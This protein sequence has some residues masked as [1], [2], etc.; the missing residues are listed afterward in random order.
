MLA[1][2]RAA[3]V[4]RKRTPEPWRERPLN[5]ARGRSQRATTGVR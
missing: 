1:H 2:L 4:T 3:S 5:S